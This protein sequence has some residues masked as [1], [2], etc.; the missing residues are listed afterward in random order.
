MGELQIII[1]K[2]NYFFGYIKLV[3][4]KRPKKF[5]VIQTYFDL[6]IKFVLWSYSM[7]RTIDF[8]VKEIQKEFNFL[9]LLTEK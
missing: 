7:Y 4:L 8:S 3:D 9:L 5:L 1:N 2:K 6:R